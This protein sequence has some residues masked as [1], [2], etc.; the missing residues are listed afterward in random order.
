MASADALKVIKVNQIDP[1]IAI[2]GPTKESTDYKKLK[3]S[4]VSAMMFNVGGLYD[5]SHKKKLYKNP[6][7]ENQVNR[8]LAVNLPY[9]LYADVR[10]HSEIEADAECRALYYILAEYSPKLGLW[11]LI[12][13]GKDLALNDKIIDVYY[14]YIERWG[15]VGRCGIYIEKSKINTISWSSYQ[16]KFYLCAID[17]M[18]NFKSVEGKL[19]EPSMFEVPD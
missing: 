3:D 13:T 2:I 9:A 1:Y 11:L 18:T 15:L 8:C 4:G 10:A 5:G 7:L 12:N 17:R 16:D 19:L 14:K 6:Y